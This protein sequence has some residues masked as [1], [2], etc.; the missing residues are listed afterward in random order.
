MKVYF[1]F[2]FEFSTT[3]NVCLGYPNSSVLFNFLNEITTE[4]S[5]HMPYYSGTERIPRTALTDT[6]YTDVIVFLG[7]DPREMQ[8][9]LGHLNYSTSKSAIRFALSKFK[10]VFED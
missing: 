2:P 4:D 3:N 6:E 5:L 8:K 10:L 9:V 1:L 7:S